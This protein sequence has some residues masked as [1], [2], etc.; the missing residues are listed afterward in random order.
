MAVAVIGLPRWPKQFMGVAVK[1]MS[2]L[3]SSS[4]ANW[5]NGASFEAAPDADGFVSFTGFKGGYTLQSDTG[6]ASLEL[7]GPT[8]AELRLTR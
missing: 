1:R 3:P 2:P 8:E 6:S 5:Q 4:S 7:T